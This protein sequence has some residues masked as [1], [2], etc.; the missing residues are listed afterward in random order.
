[1]ASQTTQNNNRLE[2][3]CPAQGCRRIRPYKV[4]GF[5]KNH[6]LS[7]HAPSYSNETTAHADAQIAFNNALKKKLG[8]VESSM[9]LLDLLQN[10]LGLEIGEN[11]VNEA[12]ENEGEVEEIEEVL[13][14]GFVQPQIQLQSPARANPQRY[15]PSDKPEEEAVAVTL[16][17][18]DMETTGFLSQRHVPDVVD[19]FLLEPLNRGSKHHLFK[20]RCQFNPALV[21][22]FGIDVAAVQSRPYHLE[23]KMHE[24]RTWI[25]NVAPTGAVIFIA[26]NGNRFDFKIFR[27]YFHQFVGHVPPNWYFVDS[28]PLCKEFFNTKI[29][30]M[31]HLCTTVLGLDPNDLHAADVDVKYLWKIL[32]K[33]VKEDDD[34]AATKVLASRCMKEIFKV[35]FSAVEENACE[36][37]E[38]DFEF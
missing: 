26:H 15:V 30:N 36:I 35:S 28:L 32:K 33:G 17:L 20:N 23:D 10:G 22:K 13:S 11:D 37:E 5:L 27:H 18:M 31:K 21:E 24:I 3:Y 16:L 8:H 14:F 25:D 2:A 4:A 6:L 9:S 29:A 34:E 7:C 1:V 38:E 19:L 12:E